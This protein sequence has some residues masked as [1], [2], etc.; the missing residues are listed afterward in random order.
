MSQNVED[1]TRQAQSAQEKGLVVGSLSYNV[2]A[3]VDELMKQIPPHDR[4]KV[5]S[6]LSQPDV[7]DLLYIVAQFFA[8]SLFASSQIDSLSPEMFEKLRVQV[9]AVTST[10]LRLHAHGKSFANRRYNQDFAHVVA[11]DKSKQGTA[12]EA[13]ES[14]TEAPGEDSAEKYGV[15]PATL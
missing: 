15:D 7:G 3:A 2:G 1:A 11:A 12:A 14:T 5:L 6:V 10:T 9:N 4:E 8:N 13:E